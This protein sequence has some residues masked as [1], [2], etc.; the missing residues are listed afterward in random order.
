MSAGL[1]VGW[2]VHHQ[3]HGHLH[4][5]L[6]V[7]GA[8]ILGGQA[9]AGAA[10]HLLSRDITLDTF[11]DDIAGLIEAEEQNGRKT[12]ALT[13][14]GRAVA[15]DPGDFVP[16]SVELA[17]HLVNGGGGSGQDSSDES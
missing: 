15:A 2:Y 5:A 17:L 12:Y 4:R 3:G 10:R 13:E 6:A 1:R 11:V 8:L 7:A 9:V 16:D 14:A